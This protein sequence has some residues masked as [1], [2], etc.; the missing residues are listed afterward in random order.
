[1]SSREKRENNIAVLLRRETSKKVEEAVFS[2]DGLAKAVFFI[3]AEGEIVE[4]KILAL[5]EL[6]RAIEAQASE[7]RELTID[8]RAE[9]VELVGDRFRLLE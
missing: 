1:M 9:F 6:A 8:D 2:I 3:V 5:M 7:I 4:E